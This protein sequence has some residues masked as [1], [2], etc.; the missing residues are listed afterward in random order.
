MKGR[1]LVPAGSLAGALTL[2]IL[3][4]PTVL[5]AA[6]KLTGGVVSPV[7]GTTTTVFQYSVH[8]VGSDTDEAITVT[9]VVAGSSRPLSLVA[10]NLRNGTW[11]GSSTLPA[12]SWSLTYRATSSGGTNPTFGPISV[13]VTAPTPAPT[14][15]PPPPA[16]TPR[17]TA[18]Q[19]QRPGATATPKPGGTPLPA[20][21]S[22]PFGTT[23]VDPS[24]SPGSAPPTDA[25]GSSSPSASAVGGGSPASRNPL[26]VPVEGVVAIGLLGAVAAAAALGERRRR[27]A[28][29]AF[30]AAGEPGE[31][32]VD[33]AAPAGQGPPEG[34]EDDETVGS[35]E[36]E[37]PDY[38]REP[39]DDL[40]D[41]V[42][43]EPDR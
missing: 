13:V 26:R 2:L 30:R 40:E 37:T 11:T 41:E 10:G 7:T 12:G 9:V 39:L 21:S 14:P 3:A 18:A 8:F 34:W 4:T 32:P 20:P 1:A 28:V 31:S 29:E 16:A 15:T 6:A 22:T 23:V 5:A 33:R 43:D 17:P 25:S 35:I 27:R 42:L 38:L 36:Y 24:G 19:T